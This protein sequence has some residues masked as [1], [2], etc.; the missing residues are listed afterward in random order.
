MSISDEKWQ[1]IRAKW[2]TQTETAKPADFKKDLKKGQDAEHNFFMKFQQH[3]TRTDGR[4]GDFLINKTEEILELKTDFYDPDS[5]PNIFIEKYSYQDKPGGPFQS[6]EHGVSYYA[7]WFPKT[8]LLLLFNVDQ[9]IKR[10]KK[11]EANLKTV[12]IKNKNYS[13][14]G[15]LVDRNLLQDILLDPEEVI[16]NGK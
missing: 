12:S 6:K 7:Y 10:I 13:T 4:R 3:M 16:L 5:T 2:A 8:D 11:L 14:L 9:L 1:Q 15:Y